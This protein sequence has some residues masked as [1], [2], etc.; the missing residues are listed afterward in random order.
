MCRRAP[1]SRGALPRPRGPAHTYVGRGSRVQIFWDTQADTRAGG[2]WCAGTVRRGPPSARCRV[3]APCTFGFQA[4][5]LPGS[6]G[7]A[8]HLSAQVHK[9]HGVWP[10]CSDPVLPCR[11]T[12]GFC[13]FWRG[14]QRGGVAKR[15]ARASRTAARSQTP[16]A[17][18]RGWRGRRGP[19]VETGGRSTHS[20]PCFQSFA[21]RSTRHFRARIRISLLHPPQSIVRRRAQQRDTQ[22]RKMSSCDPDD[23]ELVPCACAR[24]A[25]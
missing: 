19:A 2:Q 4:V 10:C 8:L 23:A 3:V 21:S 11:T 15:M 7:Y 24:H 22:A 13:P 17:R 9:C 5:S 6:P 14:A 25:S 16:N 1:P 18:G 12:M 20:R